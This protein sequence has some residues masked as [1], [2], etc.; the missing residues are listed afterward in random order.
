MLWLLCVVV[1]VFRVCL[2]YRFSLFVYVC[3]LRASHIVCGVRLR[4]R[5]VLLLLCFFPMCV[6]VFVYVAAVVRFVL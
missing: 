1:D 3:V 6:D 2:W 4:V 5:F